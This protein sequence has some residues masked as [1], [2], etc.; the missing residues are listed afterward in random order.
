MEVWFGGSCGIDVSG[1]SAVR[2]FAAGRRGGRGGG[3]AVGGVR[4]GVELFRSRGFSGPAV[5][6]DLGWPAGAAGGAGG[7]RLGGFRAGRSVGGGRT[8][9]ETGD[10]AA[11]G[12]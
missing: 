2:R 12:E 1:G 10:A 9:V 5:G 8:D 11:R 3:P 4:G 7:C 6:G